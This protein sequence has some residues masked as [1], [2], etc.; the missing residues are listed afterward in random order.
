[1]ANLTNIC[2]ELTFVLLEKRYGFIKIETFTMKIVYLK[3]ID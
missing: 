3:L 2:N 1:M